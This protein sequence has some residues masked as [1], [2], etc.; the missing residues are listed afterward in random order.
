[1]TDILESQSKSNNE[2]YACISIEKAHEV[3]QVI[4]KMHEDVKIGK[5]APSY[6]RAKFLNHSLLNAKDTR[7]VIKASYNK[8]VTIRVQILQWANFNAERMLNY[9][10]SWMPFFE[11]C[12]ESSQLLGRKVFKMITER[13]PK[14]TKHGNVVNQ[15]GLM[16]K[17]AR[18]IESAIQDIDNQMAVLN[19]KKMQLLTDQNN[20]KENRPLIK[21]SDHAVIRYLQRVKRSEFEF[22]QLLTDGVLDE[23]KVKTLI[24]CDAFYEN[25]A[26]AKIEDV[27]GKGTPVVF[28]DKKGQTRRYT[29]KGDTIVTIL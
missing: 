2:Y 3:L 17:D 27:D 20:I 10:F 11:C 12:E 1:M 24:L 29:I 22:I 19:N 18:S 23:H 25:L 26:T 15:M 5:I 28:V 14:L 16:V 7:R 8:E 21:V 9:K 6:D 4:N 13:N